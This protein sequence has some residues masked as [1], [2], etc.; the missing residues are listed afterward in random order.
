MK[1]NLVCK[2]GGV[3]GIALV[4]SIS[5]LEDNGYEWNQL[6]G[7]SAG[8]VV[9]SLLAVGYTADEIKDILYNLDFN[10][11]KGGNKFHSFFYFG[12]LSSL[13]F[14]KGLHSGDYIESFMTEKFKAKGKLKFRDISKNGISRLKIIA[15]DVTRK[16]LLI[17]PDDL[18]D[19]GI[20]PLDFEIAK[21]VRMS[22]CIPLYY[23][24]VT[25]N[26][27]NETC[28]I[29]DGGLLS[30]FPIW[31]FDTNTTPQYP[32]LGLNLTEEERINVDKHTNLVSYLLDVVYTSLSTNEDIY[33][34]EKDFVRIINIPTFD[35]DAT[36]FNLDRESKDKLFESGQESTKIFLKNWNFDNYIS[37]Y[38]K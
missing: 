4:G 6:A 12:E 14:R 26:Y 8:A 1:A 21:A 30:N 25:L 38:Y 37:R 11:F 24:P 31:I 23:S 9:T 13:F 19:Y 7:T 18:V 22:T 36:N 27:K 29:V 17:L 15:S 32:T 3:K 20:D 33:Y 16:K 28:F 2:G 34:K 10:K 5:H 35:I